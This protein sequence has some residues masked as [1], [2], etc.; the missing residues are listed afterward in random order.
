MAASLGLTTDH[1]V[2]PDVLSGRLCMGQRWIWRCCGGRQLGYN[3]DKRQQ[4]LKL[5]TDN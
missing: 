3:G 1:S 2:T 5:K 4:Q